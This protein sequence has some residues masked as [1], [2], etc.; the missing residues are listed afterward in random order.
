[1]KTKPN[2][3]RAFLSLLALRA[4]RRRLSLQNEPPFAEGF[5]GVRVRRGEDT[6]HANPFVNGPGKTSEFRAVHFLARIFP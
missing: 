2:P 5:F 6:G 1:M 3:T 4:G